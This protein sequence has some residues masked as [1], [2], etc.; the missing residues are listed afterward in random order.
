MGDG[1]IA[2]D[3]YSVADWKIIREAVAG[4]IVIAAPPYL[5]YA[6]GGAAAPVLVPAAAM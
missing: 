3:Y 2:Y 4:I 5:I 1:I 6:A